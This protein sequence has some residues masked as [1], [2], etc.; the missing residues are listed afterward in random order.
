M[1]G[2]PASA[3]LGS[4]LVEHQEKIVKRAGKELR[5]SLDDEL[6]RDR[7]E[8]TVAAQAAALGSL[9]LDRADDAPRLWAEEIRHLGGEAL[10]ARRGPADLVREFGALELAVLD[11]WERRAGPMDFQ[12]ARLL[13]DCVA[14]GC[15]AVLADFV[16]RVRGEQVEFRESA[17]MHT[18]LEH[19]DE[20]L[21]L[22]EGDGT[23]SFATG[24]AFRLLGGRIHGA[25]GRSVKDPAMEAL[26]AEARAQ[27]LEGRPIGPE[28]L[29]CVRTLASGAPSGPLLVQVRREGAERILE[30]GAVP[31]F[32]EEAARLRGVIMTV[33]DRTEEARKALELRQAHRELAELHTRLLHRSRAQAMGELASGAAHAL[34]N[35]LNAMHLRLRLLRESPGPEQVES[36]ERAVQDTAKL[37]AWLQQFASQRAAGPVEA[38]ELDGVVR[39]AIALVR[40]EA[41]RTGDSGVKLDYRA[42]AAPAVRCNPSELRE[43]LVTLLLYVR[44]QL[45]AGGQLTIRTGEDEGRIVCRLGFRA[46]VGGPARP[47]EWFVPAGESSGPAALALAAMT[48]R[49]MLSRWG[50]G[51]ETRSLE[52]GGAE[53]VLTFSPAH[54]VEEAPQPPEAREAF[55]RHVLVVDDDEDNAAMLAEVLATEGHFT[56]TA[57]SGKEALEKWRAGP[58]DVALV[59]LL[60]PDTSGT[61]LAVKLHAEKPGARLAL[62]TGW[63]LDE[64]MRRAAPVQAVFRKPVDLGQ[65]L[66]F[67]GPGGEVEAPAPP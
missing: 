38:V 65:L 17:L 54:L 14:E 52:D 7:L 62:V 25:L 4:F 66:G 58:F 43:I 37:V 2:N 33:R 10:E 45:A 19:L 36:L 51:L 11:E 42:G 32:E 13:S 35:L 46:D 21:L 23:F 53:F 6:P 16:R 55:H 30:L 40:P 3:L 63:E 61:D 34:N 18:L 31:I 9:L 64:E 29:P 1:A 44:D 57:S 60:M 12:V 59:D 49:E 50:G 41:R 28:D 20:G 24:P 22:V 48:A 67:L 56:A 47:E 26:L 15:A 27:T 5:R 8:R 39:E